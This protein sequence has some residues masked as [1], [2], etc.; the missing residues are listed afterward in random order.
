MFGCASLAA[1]EPGAALRED[2][3]PGTANTKPNG[4]APRGAT[5]ELG[6]LFQKRATLR[7][8][9]VLFFV[10]STLSMACTGMAH[11]RLLPC[12][13]CVQR[14]G[15]RMILQL[16]PL[17]ARCCV[18]QRNR[19]PSHPSRHVVGAV[20][21][22]GGSSGKIKRFCGCEK[23]NTQDASALGF[24]LGIGFHRKNDPAAGSPT[25]TLLRLLLPLMIK[26]RLSSRQKAGPTT[27]IS[28]SI[29]N[30]DGRCVQM[31]GT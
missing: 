21:N 3:R 18:L 1:S 27:C 24:F 11:E 12:A 15:N 30:N 4:H 13:I 17:I 29:G 25:A 5:P 6:L 19:K 9:W 26:Y 8:V 2:R 14:F 31:A 10:C 23:Q 7:F 28:P 20:I 22:P 16:I